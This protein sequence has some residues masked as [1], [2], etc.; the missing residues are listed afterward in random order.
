MSDFPLLIDCPCCKLQVSRQAATCPQC[1]QP[2]NT[3]TGYNLP[4]SL[5]VR[6]SPSSAAELG[7]LAARFWLAIS[8]RKGEFTFLL[9]LSCVFIGILTLILFFNTRHKTVKTQSRIT[10]T[11]HNQL[12]PSSSVHST[13]TAQL[14]NKESSLD[15][16]A[17]YKKGGQEGRLQ[18]NDGGMPQQLYFDIV[19]KGEA[20]KAK[21]K[22][23]NAYRVGWTDGWKDGYRKIKPPKIKEADLEHLSWNNAKPNVKL[24]D[25]EGNS[26]VTILDVDQ[27]NG[28]I[29]VKYNKDRNNVIEKK[30]LNALSE[31]WF[32]RKS[33]ESKIKLLSIAKRETLLSKPTEGDETVDN[34]DS[35]NN[36]KIIRYHPR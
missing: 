34:Q 26:E 6:T 27:P 13:D 25:N 32:V 8:R 22:D 18:A 3:N 36:N 28:L 23:I 21:T 24:Y 16:K 20:E 1:G 19:S 17:G 7:V 12:L 33:S 31:S 9:T 11:A 14:V 30:L 5:V 29:T 10:E 4:P 2:I 15:Y 35:N